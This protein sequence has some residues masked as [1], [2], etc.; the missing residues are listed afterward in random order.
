MP[1]LHY[2]MFGALALLCASASAQ[3]VS[4]ALEAQGRGVQ[5][6]TCDAEKGWIFKAP[7]ATLY[8]DGKTV[9]TH[10]AGPRW[11]WNDGSAITGKVESQL[12]APNAQSDITWLVL[13]ATNV[14]GAGGALS[15]V[16]TVRRSDT[17]GGVAPATGCDAAHAGVAVRV[18]YTA[19]YSFYK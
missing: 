11:T 8:I 12:P 1:M 7:E 15:G 2:G 10:G 6:Y 3:E 14:G 5:I 4:P 9:G 16:K 17:H 13:Q 19:T 18:P